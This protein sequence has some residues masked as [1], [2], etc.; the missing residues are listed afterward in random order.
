MQCLSV[1]GRERAELGDRVVVEVGRIRVLR[2]QTVFNEI[3]DEAAVGMAQADLRRLGAAL[4]IID[5]ECA[6]RDMI[7]PCTPSS[8]RCGSGRAASPPSSEAR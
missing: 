2:V 8:R 3:C 5:V 7:T 4:E 1:C 6:P